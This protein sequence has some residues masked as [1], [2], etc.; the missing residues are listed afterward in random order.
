[1]EN[2]YIRRYWQS[3][4][5]L[6]AL[7]LAT[8]QHTGDE[9]LLTNEL[10]PVARAV[11]RFYALHYPNDSEGRLLLKPAQSL[12]TWWETENPMPEIAGLHYLLHNCWP[13][14]ILTLKWVI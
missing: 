7:M 11:L 2:Q 4:F 9:A 3:G 6:I 1:M 12:E 14:R 13:C 10:L 5:E 8:Y